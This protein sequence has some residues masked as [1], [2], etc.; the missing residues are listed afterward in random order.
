MT[1]SLFPLLLPN[2]PTVDNI[3]VFLFLLIQVQGGSEL[4]SK[5]N[6]QEKRVF[7]SFV[8]NVYEGT[9]DGHMTGSFSNQLMLGNLTLGNLSDISGTAPTLFILFGLTDRPNRA[10]FQ[11]YTISVSLSVP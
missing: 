7:L 3:I 2:S 10:A 4:F 9:I 6:E 11:R 1:K 8:L 5:E